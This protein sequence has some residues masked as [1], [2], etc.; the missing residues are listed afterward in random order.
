[1]YLDPNAHVIDL[2][3]GQLLDSAKQ[4][5]AANAIYDKVPA[6]SPMKPTAV[7]RIAENLD[8]L[9]NRDE[10]LRRLGNI[11]STNPS[12]IEALSVLG[13]HAALGAEICRGGGHLQQGDRCHWRRRPGRLALLLRARHLL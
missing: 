13:R 7:V 1:M 5:D 4:H 12:D 3:Y 10:A 2:V 9:G 11:V 8:A 6:N